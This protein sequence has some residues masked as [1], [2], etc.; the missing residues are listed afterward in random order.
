MKTR[1]N[2]IHDVRYSDYKKKLPTKW[3][4]Q[5]QPTILRNHDFM[6]FHTPCVTSQAEKLTIR[7]IS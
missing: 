5:A 3:Q 1:N 2:P 6:K 4:Q 7:N